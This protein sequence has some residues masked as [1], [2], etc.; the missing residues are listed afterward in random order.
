M[1]FNKETFERELPAIV[2][3]LVAQGIW[4]NLGKEISKFIR[5]RF[6]PTPGIRVCGLS[7]YS[8]NSG[9][10]LQTLSWQVQCKQCNFIIKLQRDKLTPAVA[11][12]RVQNHQ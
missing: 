9:E 8:Q 1:R 3:T 7:M 12:I 6:D 10:H 5:R 11:T 2:D 4:D